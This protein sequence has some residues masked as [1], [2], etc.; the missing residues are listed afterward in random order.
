VRSASALNPP[1]PLLALLG[2]QAGE[3]EFLE[4]EEHLAEAMDHLRVAARILHERLGVRPDCRSEALR[5]LEA[6]CPMVP[7]RREHERSDGHVVGQ[8]F[9]P[10]SLTC[11]REQFHSRTAPIDKHKAYRP[12]EAAA[13]DLAHRQS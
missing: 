12:G 1:L 13:K 8:A 6:L 3:L 5:L 11:R 4:S 7:R 10:L 2:T 9:P